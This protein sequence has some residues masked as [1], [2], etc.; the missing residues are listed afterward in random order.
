MTLKS[1]KLYQQA[2]RR[3]PGGVN[4]PVRAFKSIGISPPFIKA[5]KGS[6]IWD[7][8]ENEYID[9]VMSWGALILGHAYPDIVIA[10]QKQAGLGTSYG[11]CTRLEVEMVEKPVADGG[12]GTIEALYYGLGGRLV[13]TEITGPLWEKVNAQYLILD[14]QKTAIIE[15]AQAAGLTLVPIQKRNPRYTTTFGVGELVNNAVKN[16]CK[17]VILAI[18]GSATNDG[19]MGALAALGVKFYDENQKLLPG[20]G[21]NLPKVQAIDTEGAEKAMNEVEIL[22]ASD[23]KNSLFGPEGAASVYAPQKGANEEDVFFS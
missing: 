6:H 10:L 8:D 22:I 19:G 14:D 18:G 21:E 11:A 16:G 17:K 5:G 23:V 7:E 13:K 3:M 2:K 4:S 12:E 9:Y 20:M 15:M 1:E